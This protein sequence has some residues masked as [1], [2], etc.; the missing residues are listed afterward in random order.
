LV[1]TDTTTLDELKRQ[2]QLVVDHQTAERLGPTRRISWCV[3][4]TI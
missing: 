4:L 1:V 3:A 2:L